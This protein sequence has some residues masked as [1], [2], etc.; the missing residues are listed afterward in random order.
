MEVTIPAEGLP[1]PAVSL[2]NEVVGSGATLSQGIQASRALAVRIATG[3]AA[4]SRYA[5][6]KDFIKVFRLSKAKT[7]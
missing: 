1:W 2:R 7:F 6:R 3:V 4:P 5:V